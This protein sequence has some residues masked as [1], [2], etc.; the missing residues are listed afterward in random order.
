MSWSKTEP[1]LP[2]GS[3][4]VNM[5]TTTYS[6]SNTTI[7]SVVY[8]ARLDSNGFALKVV[9]SRTHTKYNLTNLYLRCDIDGVTGIPE[10]TITGTSSNGSTTAYFTGEAAEGV[11]ILVTVSYQDSD[12]DTRDRLT[13]TAP[14]I[15]IM[16]AIWQKRNGTWVQI[17]VLS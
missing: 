7:T 17:K 14:E 11:T 2:E 6:D 4:W 3:S 5:G 16:R 15:L 9:E 13:F 8:F 12:Y 1:T 10:T